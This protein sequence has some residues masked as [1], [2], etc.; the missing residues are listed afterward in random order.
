MVQYDVL[1]KV[2]ENL[3]KEERMGWR[4]DIC[5]EFSEVDERYR[6]TDWGH[7][8]ASNWNKCKKKKYHWGKLKSNYLNNICKK[9]KIQPE[10]TALYLGEQ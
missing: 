5:R 4:Q 8:E 3:E 9:K 2:V 1:I 7:L 10:K 6:S